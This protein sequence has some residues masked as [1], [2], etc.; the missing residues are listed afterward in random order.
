MRDSLSV[1]AA[2]L[3]FS[4]APGCGSPSSRES[5]GTSASDLAG[6]AASAVTPVITFAADWTQTASQPLVA[7]QTVQLA[8]D[9]ARLPDCRGDLPTGPGWTISAITS[10]NGVP[11]DAVAVAGAGLS[12]GPNPPVITLPMAGDLQ[13]WFQVGSVWGC[14]AYDSSYGQNYHFTVGAPANAPGWVGDAS[15]LIDRATCGFGSSAGPCYADA[16]PAQGGFSFDTWAR[17]QAAITQVFFDVWKQG[18]TDFQNPSLWRELDVELHSRIGPEG[19]LTTSYVDFSEY[20]GNNARYAIDLR[21]LDPLPGHDGGAL[22]DVSQ[23]PTFP[24]TFSADKQYV[25]ADF[26]FYVTV[27]GVALQPSGGGLFHGL[28]QNYL[29]LYAICGFSG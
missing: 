5:S 15:V 26:E 21:A 3:L 12:N 7:G 9:A 11:G 16:A 24:V 20:T 10:L 29:G 13:I 27:N 28:Y 22:T 14:T 18:V 2:L 6:G 19:P 23:C 17:Q 25:Q 4:V 8:Y 1:M